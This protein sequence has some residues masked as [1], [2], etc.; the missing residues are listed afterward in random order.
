MFFD[1]AGNCPQCTWF[2]ETNMPTGP[3]QDWS[4]VTT[5]AVTEG[6]NGHGKQATFF[7]LIGAGG[8]AV[9]RLR[10]RQRGAGKRH[11]GVRLNFLD[12]TP[13]TTPPVTITSADE[14]SPAIRIHNVRLT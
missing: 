10:A 7:R 1:E 14:G 5:M 6:D 4:S 13:G 2:V 11:G 12:A 9:R 3:G 8:G